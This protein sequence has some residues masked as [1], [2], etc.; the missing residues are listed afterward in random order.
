MTT[1]TSV[2]GTDRLL[3]DGIAHH[4]AGRLGEAAR[5]YGEIL[6]LEPEHVEALRLL[7]GVAAQTG[8]LDQAAGFWTAAAGLCPGNS[9][10]LYNLAT[11][12][13]ALGHPDEAI[14]RYREALN[15][16]PDYPEALYNLG[17]T[18][19]GRGRFGEAVDCYRQALELRPGSPDILNN[20]GN[21]L[22]SLGRPGEAADCYRRAIDLQAA[23][24]DALYNLGNALLHL[25]RPDE[26]VHAYRRAL[27]HRPAFPEAHYNLGNALKERQRLAEAAENYREAARLRPG[28]AEALTNEGL[29][30][31]KLGEFEAGWRSYEARWRVQGGQPHGHRQPLWDGEGLGGRT[32][33]LH[34]EQGLGDSLQFVRYARPV[35]E[36][37]GT[38]VLLCPE[39]LARLFG[40]VAGI[41]LVVTARDRIPPC[42][43]QAP[44]LSLPMLLG[45]TVA[46]IPHDV[47]YLHPEPGL[48]AAWRERLEAT[49][50]QCRIGLV[51]AG[52][53]R[54]HNPEANRIDRRRSMRLAEFSPLAGLPGMCFFSLQKGE[55]ARQVL[56]APPGLA[57][58]DWTA[59]LHD[60]ADTA[61]LVANLDLVISVDTAVA[62]LA[63][64]M[65]RP[66]WLLSR[67]DGCWR[68][69]CGRDDSPWYPT[70]RLFH[71]PA[72]GDWAPVVERLR[73][74]LRDQVSFMVGQ[75]DSHPSAVP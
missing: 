14:G 11:A 50:G 24:P 12:L 5:L 49:R 48:V 6:S 42:D 8:R 44:L 19:H 15:A 43:C 63:G 67:F 66:V 73:D 10:I 47:P 61:A 46:T 72:P 68:W 2:T 25:G 64:A 33:L 53:P 74:A 23:F 58:T 18:L 9:E 40:T 4:R 16:Q 69:L 31:L 39:P 36:R 7:G 57:L 45:T 20:L 34:C 17:N 27:D 26:A 70:L 75:P 3:A 38:V 22:L 13:C 41:D 35:K 29:A 59:D 54:P 65:A 56:E 30:R 55:A 32:I 60:F 1:T 37:G 51:W 52:D 21:A 28:Y 62:H 71:Q